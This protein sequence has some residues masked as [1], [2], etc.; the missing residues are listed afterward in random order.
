MIRQMSSLESDRTKSYAESVVSGETIAGPYVRA[1]C[2][3]HLDDLKNGHKRGLVFDH[4]AAE[5]VFRFFETVLYLPAEGQ[6]ED[7][8]FRLHPSQAFIIGSLFGWKRK[9]GCRRFRRAYI[10][11]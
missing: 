3:R 9:D 2:H 7:Q 10:I 11:S 8:P 6:F 4:E 1:A 5:R